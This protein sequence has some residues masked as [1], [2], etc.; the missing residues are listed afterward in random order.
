M[1][2]LYIFKISFKNENGFTLL[3]EVEESIHEN[4]D[5]WKFKSVDH[6]VR[7]SLCL[8]YLALLLCTLNLQSAYQP[9]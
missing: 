7:L 3:Q 4:H 2:I 9:Y 8:A 1:F 5:H 6:E